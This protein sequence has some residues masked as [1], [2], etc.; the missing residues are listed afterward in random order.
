MTDKLF[1]RVIRRMGYISDQSGIYNRYAR[2]AEN[3][4]SHL[5]KT[6][7]YISS[8]ILNNHFQTATILGSGWL[9]DLPL[10]FLSLRLQKILLYDVYH[11]PQI[12]QKLKKYNCFELITADITG[13]YMASVYEAVNLYRNSKTKTGI[14]DLKFNGFRPSEDTDCY[15]SLNILNQLDILMIDF[16]R[17]QNIYSTE[18]LNT[19]RTRI[20]QNHL[21]TLPKNK[22]CL[23]TDFEELVFRKEDVPVISK[24]LLYTELPEGKN[25]QIW[26]WLFD[27]TGSYNKG[28]KTIFKVIAMEI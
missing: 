17:R 9:L 12:R 10:E 2:E 1:H 3:W 19:L 14:A 16:L 13:G 18:E 23:I 24:N 27:T 4:N 6:K 20:Q 25:I 21:E 11:P 15:I 7:Q 22:S 26:E 5:E 28:Y 8:Y